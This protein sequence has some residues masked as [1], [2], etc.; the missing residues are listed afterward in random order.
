MLLPVPNLE[1]TLKRY[2]KWVKPLITD[3]EHKN[4]LRIINEFKNGVAQKLQRLLE[5]QKEI[6]QHTSWIS[7]AWLNSYL[8]GRI[9][10]I[11]GS[12]FSS[13][14]KIDKEYLNKY[15]HEKFISNFVS[16]LAEICRT[17][18]IGTFKKVYNSRNKEICL[19]QFQILKGASRVPFKDRDI[20]NI[21]NYS[22]NYITLF[23]KN[24]VFKIQVLNAEDKLIDINSSIIEILNTTEYKEY[25][26]S[27]I[28]FTDSNRAYGLRKKYYDSNAF[29]NILENS[30]F[31]I[32]IFHEDLKSYEEEYMFYMYLRADNSWIYKPLNFIYNLKDK[33]M[34][35][36]CE[37]TYQDA[38][39]ILEILK[40]TIEFMYQGRF[41]FSDDKSSNIQINEYFDDDYKKEA[42]SIK[43]DYC[44]KINNFN[45]KNIFIE[46][47]ESYFNTHLKGLS[48]DAIMQFLLQYGQYKAFGVVRGMYE[49]VDIREYQYA[50]TECVRSV[51]CESL[52]FIKSLNKDDQDTYH[53]LKIAE[54]EHKNRIKICKLCN[55]VNRHLYGLSLMINKLDHIE[56]QERAHNFFRDTSYLKISES[57]LST[58]SIGYNDYMEYLLFSPV[59]EKGFGVNYY[60]N[61][62]GIQFI[63]SYHISQEDRAK[64]FFDALKLGADKIKRLRHYTKNL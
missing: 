50:R 63:I 58:T 37:H 57:F 39:T 13:L 46:F 29:F 56:D 32:S 47:D 3:K 7:D 34:Y 42:D 59:M 61:S 62:S 41:N 54:L 38:G 11:I 26:L 33:K 45:I 8:D 55:G 44:N 31:N 17:Y 60:C 24:N 21:S 12:N 40:R 4:T 49:A 28:C 5:E 19:S 14:I 10:P 35:I 2:E 20:Y 25:S 30:L 22:S 16:S 64:H 27:T 1:E 51:S 48:K 43:K 18:K 53:Q 36:N 9:T 15:S 52:A 23:Y 6:Y